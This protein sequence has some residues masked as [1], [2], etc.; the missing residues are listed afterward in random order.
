MA[1]KAP[2]KVTSSNKPPKIS[3]MTEEEKDEKFHQIEN[4]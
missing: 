3:T 2:P 1:Q 4:V